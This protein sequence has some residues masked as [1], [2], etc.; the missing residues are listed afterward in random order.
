MPPD[1]RCLPQ[2]EALTALVLQSP[3]GSSRCACKSGSGAYSGDGFERGE[4]ALGG[5]GVTVVFVIASLWEPGLRWCG[6]QTSV[7]PCS[8]WRC[9]LRF[10]AAVRPVVPAIGQCAQFW[11]G[12]FPALLAGVAGSSPF[13]AVVGESPRGGPASRCSRQLHSVFIP[14]A[15]ILGAEWM[16]RA[17]K[18]RETISDLV[19]P[20]T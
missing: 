3:Q 4:G 13:L 5:S 2:P 20:A 18:G 16:F 19:A 9:R 8:G 1:R 12:D 17:E 7:E 14:G 10:R 11:Q 6:R 15:R